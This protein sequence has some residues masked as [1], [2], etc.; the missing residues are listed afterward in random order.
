MNRSKHT[1]DVEKVTAIDG[2]DVSLLTPDL[3]ALMAAHDSPVEPVDHNTLRC[4]AVPIS[5][6]FSK[7]KTN[8]LLRRMRF[9][10]GCNVHVDSDLVYNG[11]EAGLTAALAGPCYK[12]WRKLRVSPL[13]GSFNQVLIETLGLLGSPLAPVAAST[14]DG[15]QDPGANSHQLG[16]I[17][18]GA[19]QFLSD[20]QL[21]EAAG[22]MVRP[23]LAEQVAKPLIRT[24]APSSVVLCGEPGCGA[25]H[26][27]LS[28]AHLLRQRGFVRRVLRVAASRFAA[29]HVFPAELDAT[30]T[31]ALAEA[32]QLKETLI[33]VQDLD[34]CLTHSPV[35]YAALVDALDRGMRL[36]A[37]F[38]SSDS[39]TIVTAD[40]ALARR[41]VILNVHEPQRHEVGEILRQ[42]AAQSP[43]PVCPAAIDTAMRMADGAQH[44]NP[45]A[46][47]GILSAAIA[48]AV[49]QNAKQVGPDEVFAGRDLNLF[50]DQQEE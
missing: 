21:A 47:V 22:V 49:W 11:Q 44:Q 9:C 6:E 43:I 46:A 20:S 39:A 23:G 36:L 8:L 38:R 10:A 33:V 2:D 14:L 15:S 42:Y 18:R 32:A 25:D 16:P 28:A 4:W 37:T 5:K 35:C 48:E 1:S 7:P 13:R 41:L 19:G 30:L 12:N 50:Q 26:L 45:A 34:T 3:L 24:A 17:L 31:I 29:G 27:I 40:A